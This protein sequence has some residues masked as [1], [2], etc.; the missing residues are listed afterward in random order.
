MTTPA[1]RTWWIV[2]NVN[3]I[4]ELT[5][6]LFTDEGQRVHVL[7]GTVEEDLVRDLAA[8]ADPTVDVAVAH[9]WE[10]APPELVVKAGPGSRR[11]R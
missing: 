9:G 6:V 11:H 10:Q 3:A 4:R 1:N 2:L 7:N 5:G 8:H